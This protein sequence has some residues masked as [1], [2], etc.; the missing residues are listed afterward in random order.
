MK[1][2]VLALL[3]GVSLCA[4]A[5]KPKLS[6]TQK[7][8]EAKLDVFRNQAKAALNAEYA[9]EN[10]PTCADSPDEASNRQCLWRE[11]G[12]TQKNYAAYAKALTALLRVRN[13]YA[14]P[15]MDLPPNARGIKFDQAERAW[16]FYRNATCRAVSD[17]NY[18]GNGQGQ[19]E[20]ICLQDVTRSHMHEL[21]SLYKDE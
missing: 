19:V 4:T 10:Q 6:D 20:M 21:E 8:Y 3:L 16:V 18:G 11:Y 13:P 1:R 2:A 15:L 7:V 12:I 9:R 5:Q 14:D 17:L